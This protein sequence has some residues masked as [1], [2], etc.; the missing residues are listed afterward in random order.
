MNRVIVE[1]FCCSVT[2]MANAETPTLKVTWKSSAVLELGSSPGWVPE[3][4]N[5]KVGDSS[6]E[7]TMSCEMPAGPL[8]KVSELVLRMSVSEG[9]ATTSSAL[10][11]S[12]A[13]NMSSTSWGAPAAACQSPRLVKKV[14]AVAEPDHSAMQAT[15]A[16]TYIRL[17]VVV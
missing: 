4:R 3:V 13:V 15:M 11:T 14:A 1:A 8:E 12:A 17:I 10:A 2:T 16:Q 7:S 9:G 6:S 5:S